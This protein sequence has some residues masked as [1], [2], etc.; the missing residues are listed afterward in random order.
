[1]SLRRIPWSWI[2]GIILIGLVISLAIYNRAELSEAFH[3]L[4]TT[5]PMWVAI[6]FTMIVLG[7]VC[8]GWIYGS[9]LAIL[10]HRE[11]ML[12]LIGTALV[13]ILL[14]QAVP[15]GSVAAYAFL[16]AA[17]R[18]RGFPTGS[19][20]VVAGTE[21][22][23]WNGA[24][25]LMFSAGLLYLTLTAEFTATTPIITAVLLTFGVATFLVIVATRPAESVAR[26]L[27]QLRRS[28]LKLGI[29]WDTKSL[30]LL[31][32]EIANSRAI[33]AAQPSKF[34]R[35]ILLQMSIF[36]FHALAITALLYGMRIE[37]PFFDV[38]A[39]Y[40]MSLI[41]SLF[42]VLP[43]GGG[44]VEAALSFS[45]HLQG[46]PIQG[47]LGSAI[48]FRLLSFWMMLPL[49]AVFYRLLTKPVHSEEIK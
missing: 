15:M 13:G 36:V 38:L 46:V 25:L 18:N 10:N 1:M 12:W 2:I 3:L 31:I 27:H 47:A 44:A 14:N 48:L 19:V 33:F 32:D 30:E 17:L 41:V 40:G 35:I 6:A 8:A 22:I 43:G 39:A 23:S 49:G 26:R 9:V 7:F 11:T 34:G 28:L 42:T 45:L 21:L 37:V 16:V 5:E 29:E 20:A 24:A 4:Q